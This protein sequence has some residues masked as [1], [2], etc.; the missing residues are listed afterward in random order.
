[1][2]MKGRNGDLLFANKNRS[3]PS[4]EGGMCIEATSEDFCLKIEKSDL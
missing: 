4:Y 2:E 3:Q 1:M